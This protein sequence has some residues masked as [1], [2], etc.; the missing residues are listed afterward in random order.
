MNLHW[1]SGL[2]SL[3]RCLGLSWEKAMAP[4]FSTLAWTIPWMGE[5]DRLQSMGSLGVG[6]DWATSLSLFTFI[7]WSLENPRDGGAWWA[8]VYGIAQSQTWLKR[9]SSSKFVMAFLWKSKHLLISWLWSP[10]AVFS[11]PR[12]EMCHCFYFFPMYLCFWS[13]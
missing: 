2:C 5:P 13:F 4:H 6:H 3:I 1:Q 10:S 12:K 8:A 11:S 7:H 9:L